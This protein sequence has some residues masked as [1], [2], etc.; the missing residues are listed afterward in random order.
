MIYE[1]ADNSAEVLGFYFVVFPDA[2]LFDLDFLI[3][4]YRLIHSNI[5]WFIRK[6]VIFSFFQYRQIKPKKLNFKI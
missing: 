3:V 2:N 1:I 5:N 4:R 6:I